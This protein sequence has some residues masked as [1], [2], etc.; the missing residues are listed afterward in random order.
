[1][2]LRPHFTRRVMHTLALALLVA[3]VG[4][5]VASQAQVAGAANSAHRPTVDTA[6]NGTPVVNI[7]APT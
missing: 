3:F 4:A 7:V 1:M 5:P 2:T 6:A